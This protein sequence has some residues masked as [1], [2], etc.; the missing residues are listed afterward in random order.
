VARLQLLL[1]E[2]QTVALLDP[3]HAESLD[4]AILALLIRA[5]GFHVRWDGGGSFELA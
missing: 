5:T 3:L 1:P 4:A 2:E